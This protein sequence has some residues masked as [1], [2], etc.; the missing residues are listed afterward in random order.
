V[1]GRLGGAEPDD[2][3]DAEE[4]K[5]QTQTGCGTG[6]GGGHGKYTHGICWWAVLYDPRRYCEGAVTEPRSEYEC[7]Q[8]VHLLFPRTA[9]V[10][11]GGLR[12]IGSNP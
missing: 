5:S 7:W 8:G 3:Q 10:P 4:P 2:G 12:S 9:A 1:L 6:K 11:P